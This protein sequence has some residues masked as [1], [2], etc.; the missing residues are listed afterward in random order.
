ME[1]TNFTIDGRQGSRPIVVT[2]LQPGL[3]IIHGSNRD[4]SAAYQ[5]LSETLAAHFRGSHDF[6]AISVTGSVETLAD[7]V[8]RTSAGSVVDRR[9][10]CNPSRESSIGWASAS[11]CDRQ[12]YLG[13]VDFYN[14]PDPSELAFRLLGSL[15][16]AHGNGAAFEPEKSAGLDRLMARHDELA[17][18]IEQQMAL[19][20]QQ[21]EP[22]R[23]QLGSLNEEFD[24]QSAQ[25]SELRKQLQDI[26][27]QL[28]HLAVFHETRQH[29]ADIL[30]RTTQETA[31]AE[32]LD[33]LGGQLEYWR[34][35]AN[36]QRQRLSDVQRELANLPSQDTK[37]GRIQDQRACLALL[38]KLVGT[39]RSEIASMDAR[40]ETV[41]CACSEIYPRLMPVV[42]SLEEQVYALCGQL[43][44]QQRAT[45]RIRLEQEQQHLVRCLD[46]L[47][48]QIGIRK[49]RHH[50]LNNASVSLET[51]NGWLN[52]DPAHCDCERHASFGA[53]FERDRVATSQQE[54]E[55]LIRQRN[56]LE[57]RLQQLAGQMERTRLQRAET[58]WQLAGQTNGPACTDMQR[59]LLTVNQRLRESIGQLGPQSDQRLATW[60]SDDVAVAN[61]LDSVARLLRELTRGEMQRIELRGGNALSILT[62]R[63]YQSTDSL[64]KAQRNM[65][66]LS[67]LLSFALHT[68][69]DRAVPLLLHAPFEHLDDESVLA[70][71]GVL[72]HFAESGRQVLVFTERVPVSL[73]TIPIAMRSVAEREPIIDSPPEH[74]SPWRTD[75]WVSD[76]DFD[77][78]SDSSSMSSKRY[79]R[80]RERSGPETVRASHGTDN[81]IPPK[82]TQPADE[83]ATKRSTSMLHGSRK[84]ELRK[85]S[86]RSNVQAVDSADR[87]R[88]EQRSSIRANVTGRRKQSG[89]EKSL[90]FYLD[91]GDRLEEAPSIGPK[92][93]A[94]LE[95]I[96]I[97]TVDEFLSCDAN[98]T[99]AKLK[100]ARTTVE[101]IQTWQKQSHLMCS[102][103]QIRSH[104]AQIMVACQ[105]ID[106]A[107]LRQMAPR[108]LLDIIDPFVRTKEGQRFLRS[109]NKPDLKEVTDWITWAQSSRSLKAA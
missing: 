57:D 23:Q 24:R 104:D 21:G 16:D 69:N 105:I 4:E 76:S 62:S 106:A 97:R 17:A 3:T 83:P 27:L 81:T 35:V 2:G 8:L 33:A 29:Q 94:R 70:V 37:G 30:Q 109:G 101:N 95:R 65:L 44:R 61:S 107:R 60:I 59:E 43:S 103:P 88:R 15:V 98:Q 6:T 19:I 25:V 86:A 9:P 64:D 75:R 78:E 82:P 77:T 100:N 42:G 49:A 51:F 87:N 48:Q 89:A 7:G 71:T 72:R 13:S 40:P 41:G 20:R 47:Q 22:L 54:R 31:A 53:E 11:D 18:G 1:I 92:T 67:L 14:L 36:A 91:P 32:E 66:S 96:G 99:A 73:S 93:A 80:V 56:E 90:R 46:G 63:G 39:L 108:D 58:R 102:V 34:G 26:R 84:F 10:N 50:E 85:D 38:E 74:E 52:H 12:S 5:F 79:S 55:Q 45:H 28:T 68:T